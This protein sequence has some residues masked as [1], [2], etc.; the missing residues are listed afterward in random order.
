MSVVVVEELMPK[1]CKE[2]ASL[3]AAGKDSN[4]V[5]KT[6]FIRDIGEALSG[7]AENP[8]ALHPDPERTF[9]VNGK[10]ENVR[11]ARLACGRKCSESLAVERNQPFFPA[12]PYIAVGCLR[13]R[14][15][16]TQ[17]KSVL[18]RP[19]LPKVVVWQL[20]AVKRPGTMNTRVNQGKRQ[21]EN[22]SV[23]ATVAVQGK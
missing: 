15:D 1:C 10:P 4:F 7:L 17:S 22:V 18:S 6:K 13:D 21:K 23:L 14:T 2:Q 20:L 19:L 16:L 12:D 3:H 8:R 11:D 5:W 9:S